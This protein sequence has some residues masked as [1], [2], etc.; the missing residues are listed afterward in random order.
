MGFHDSD[1][2]LCSD[3]T[4]IIDAFLNGRSCNPARND[5]LHWI[6]SSLIPAS[7]MIS[8]KY[9]PSCENLADPVS[10]GHLDNYLWHLDCMFKVPSP[11]LA[12]LSLI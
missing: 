10:H 6:T 1:I 7:I 5:C 8:P 2:T 11:L 3:N 9:V 12:W 4:G